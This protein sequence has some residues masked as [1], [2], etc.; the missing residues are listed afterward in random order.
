M[1]KKICL[2]LFLILLFIIL[3]GCTCFYIYK[4]DSNISLII[5]HGNTYNPSIEELVD[6]PNSRLIS[7]DDFKLDGNIENEESKNYPATGEYEIK[8]YYKNKILIQKVVINDTIAPE[9]TI[10]DIIEVPFN[11]DLSTYSFDELVNVSDLSEVNDYK[12]NLD[13]V[14]TAISGEYVAKI[15]V[16]DI[17]SN[18]SEKDFKI[19]VQEEAA[20]DIISN[21]NDTQIGEK[22]DTNTND[23]VSKTKSNEEISKQTK[24]SKPKSDNTNKNQ[25]TKSENTEENS[26]DIVKCGHNKDNSYSTFDEALAEYKKEEALWDYKWKY[27]NLSDEEYYKNRPKSHE[28]FR[29]AFCNRWIITITK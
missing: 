29:C 1:K 20:K 10:K 17:Y 2:V 28:E 3:G 11:T 9:I 7:I 25:P 18:K 6:I 4:V 14:N 16:D 21:S 12:I 22:K 8:I 5:E 27:E 23:N 13:N 19:I 15:M 24:P 26:K